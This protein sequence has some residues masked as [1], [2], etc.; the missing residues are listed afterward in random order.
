[1]FHNE[2]IFSS[3]LPLKLKDD[4]LLGGSNPNL[5]SNLIDNRLNRATKIYNSKENL[6]DSQQNMIYSSHKGK[7]NEVLAVNNYNLFNQDQDHNQDSDYNIES[8]SNNNHDEEITNLLNL[9]KFDDDEDN[10]LCHDIIGSI[11]INALVFILNIST[12]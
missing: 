11:L 12:R 6:T 4:S 9:N 7:T 10:F 5:N 3:N 1:L 2:F 8:R